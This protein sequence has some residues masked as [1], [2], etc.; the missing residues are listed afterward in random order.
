MVRTKLLTLTVVLIAPFLFAGMAAAQAATPAAA[1]CTVTPRTDAELAALGAAPAATPPAAAGTPPTG[2]AVDSKTFAAIQTSLDQLN[3]CQQAGNVNAVL[4][5]YTDSY[6]TNVALAPEPVPIVP[7]TPPVNE[8]T[9]APVPQ[10]SGGRALA[11]IDAYVQ[12]DGA[13]AGVTLDGA[14]LHVYTF[15]EQAGLWRINATAPFAEA[16][17]G[18]P[19]EPVQAAGTAAIAKLAA[20]AGS[21]SLKLIYAAAH[22]WR[23]GALGCPEPGKIYAQVITP[24]WL[25]LVTDGKTVLEYHTDAQQRVVLCRSFGN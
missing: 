15:V 18:V 12:T 21:A 23:D 14:A 4:A 3:A 7:G 11:L 25:A 6:V 8:A 22:E 20:G 1:T 13:V 10:P 19:A 2:D 24:G 17:A 9:P 16:A 5:L